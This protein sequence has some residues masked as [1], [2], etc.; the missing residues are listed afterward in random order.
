MSSNMFQQRCEKFTAE[1]INKTRARA[2]TIPPSRPRKM[3]VDTTRI[4]IYIY[5]GNTDNTGNTGTHVTVIR[6]LTTK[7]AIN[8][9][10][11]NVHQDRNFPE[12]A[13]ER[14]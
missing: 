10:K 2:Q 8:E 6:K 1:I 4:Y 3:K 12:E 5:T 13:P 9:E 14:K 7:M 11:E